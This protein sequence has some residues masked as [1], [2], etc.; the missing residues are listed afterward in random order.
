MKNL[1]LFFIFIILFSANPIYSQDENE[2][3]TSMEIIGLGR[4][5]LFIVENALEK[6]IGQKRNDF[7]QNEVFA[8]IVNM[9]VLEPILVELV[10]TTNGLILQ[11]TVKEKWSIFPLPIAFVGSRGFNFGVFFIDTNAFGQRDMAVIGGALGSNGWTAMAMYNHTA[12][13]KGVPGLSCAFMYNRH[14]YESVDRFETPYRFYSTDRIRLSLGLNYKFFEIL[15]S[16]FS[17]SFANISIVQND[18]AYNSP[19]EGVMLLSFRPGLSIGK[20]SWDGIFL[21]QQSIS[22]DYCYYYGIL[23]SSYNQVEYKANYE[24][25]LIPGFRLIAK[26][27]GSWKSAKDPLFE[28]GPQKA[29]VNILPSNYSSMN[30]AGLSLGLEKYLFKNNWGILSVH[31]SWQCVF[32][33]IKISDLEFDHGPSAGILFYLSQIALPAIGVDIAYNVVSELFQF[34]FSLGMSF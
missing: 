13:R 11:V 24:H 6:F 8:A 33:Y 5:K 4:T 10:N 19:E 25:S 18:N 14:D 15:T 9:S 7:D 16:S 23:G 32:S 34:S 29:Q 3:I 12:N 21:L 2:T 28:D 30:Y 31:A 26:S 27:A 1:F 22:L 17:V 20:N